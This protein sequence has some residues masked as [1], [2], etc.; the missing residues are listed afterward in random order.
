[1]A[2]DRLALVSVA[3]ASTPSALQARGRSMLASQKRKKARRD[4]TGRVF[5]EETDPRGNRRCVAHSDERGESTAERTTPR[6]DLG[7]GNMSGLRAS[8]SKRP[9]DRRR[10]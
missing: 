5:G 2:C 4:A 10:P 1:M 3:L 8:G 6:E 9:A 7:C